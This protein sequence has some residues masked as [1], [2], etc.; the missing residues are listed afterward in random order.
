MPQRLSPLARPLRKP[1]L[2]GLLKTSKYAPLLYPYY[3]RYWLRSNLG[4]VISDDA[5]HQKSLSIDPR[6]VP[7]A[8]AV[9]H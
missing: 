7:L 5:T 6:M 3:S 4:A 9:D 2:M 8:S 1:Q